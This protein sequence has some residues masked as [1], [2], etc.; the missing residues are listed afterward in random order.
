MSFWQKAWS[1][2]TAAVKDCNTHCAT[3]LLN[4]TVGPCLLRIDRQLPKVKL[5]EVLEASLDELG[6]MLCEVAAARL[7]LLMHDRHVA[8]QN[9]M[10][11]TS[12]TC[13]LQ[14]LEACGHKSLRVPCCLTIAKSCFRTEAY[15]RLSVF[16]RGLGP[17]NKRRV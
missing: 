12:L 4:C 9:S 6:R 2:T 3:A 15:R 17:A 7:E 1:T 10:E 8:G 13:R 5:S 11:A 14:V 16:L